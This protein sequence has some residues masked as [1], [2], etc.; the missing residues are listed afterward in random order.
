[1]PGHVGQALLGDPVHDQL[2]VGRQVGHRRVEAPTDG[3]AG[4]SCRSPRPA[5]TSALSSPRSSSTPGRSRRATRR[6][7][8]RLARAVSCACRMSPRTFCRGLVGNPAETQ[9]DSRQALTDLVVEL[10][11]DSLP[12]RLLSSERAAVAQAPLGLES[13]QHRIEGGDQLGHCSVARTREPL[14]GAKQIDAVHQP[15]QP[16]ERRERAPQ[17]EPLATRMKVSPTPR[18]LLR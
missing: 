17:Q 10:L 12:L 8:S 2:G 6:T 1:M 9:H 3:V 16:V 4:Q 18:R 5:R 13:R 15:N 11:R 7:S 14:P